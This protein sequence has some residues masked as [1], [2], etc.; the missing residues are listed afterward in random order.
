M[1]P[2]QGQSTARVW[3]RCRCLNLGSSLHVFELDSTWKFPLQIFLLEVCLS[4]VISI[5]GLWLA[6]FLRVASGA[7]LATVNS[8]KGERRVVRLVE[9]L[10][11]FGAQDDQNGPILKYQHRSYHFATLT[12]QNVHCYWCLSN[13]TVD[14]GAI[15]ECWLCDVNSFQLPINES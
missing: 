7:D 15:Y 6:T 5:Q 4:Q 12:A 2:R 9:W 8:K 1:C 10:W 11:T 3:T 13:V 14:S